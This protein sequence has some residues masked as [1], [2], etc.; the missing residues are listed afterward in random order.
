[1]RRRM[2]G[3]LLALVGLMAGSCSSAHKPTAKPDPYAIPP[4]ITA[5]YVNSV[6]AAL[7]HINGDVSRLLVADDGLSESALTD[8]RAVYNDPLYS[9]EVAIARQ[10]LSYLANVRR[11]PGDVVTTVSRMVFASPRC[12]FVSTASDYSAVAIS[13]G[14]R[15]ADEYWELQ[16]KAPGNDPSDINP[17]PWALAFN[18][19]YLTPTTLRNQCATS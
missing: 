2:L 11:P 7:N 17:T 16:P 18:A 9:K 6:F 1:M 12:I 5:S 15:A 4:L 3:T 14:R 8:L 10:S 19:D 13:P